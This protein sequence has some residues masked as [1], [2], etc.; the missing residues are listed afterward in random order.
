L[1]TFCGVV[2]LTL[3]LLGCGAR[4]DSGSI[5]S[6]S[7]VQEAWDQVN[8]PLRLGSGFEYR[9]GLLPAAARVALTPWTDTYWPSNRG[10]LANRWLTGQDGFSYSVLDQQTVRSLTAAQLASLSPAEKFDILNSRY[11]YPLTSSERS[12]T[13]PSDQSWF[14]LCHGW[15]NAAISYVEPKSVAMRNAEGL[16]I[17]FAA[18][19]VKA[20]LTYHQ[21]QV[22]TSGHFVLGGR[23]D[24]DLST[25]P[26]A[27]QLPQCRDTN[28]GA[29]HVVL[30]NYI[31][32]FSR[33]FVADV[34][35]DLQVW[36]QPIHEYAVTVLGYQAPS[37]GSA[38]GT[39]QEAVVETV[40]TY[41]VE[42]NPQ[43][44]ATNNSAAHRNASKRYQYVLELNTYGQIIGGQWLNADRPD[45]LWIQSTAQFSGYFTNLGPL[46]NAA[47][48]SPGIDFPR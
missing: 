16:V 11:D 42:I 10:G 15:A 38:F 9:L 24:Y 20:L 22:V 13:S 33:A 5:D 45:F 4:P 31:G 41:T 14:G 8:D 17:P 23:C 35:R 37:P 36:N 34:T 1:K 7:T 21:G 18:S 3:G 40:V 28:A 27:G 2:G 6:G 30:A 48:T 12:R 26:Q 39:V 29:F 25:Q 46:Y 44:G 19:D 43:W 32:R 47:V